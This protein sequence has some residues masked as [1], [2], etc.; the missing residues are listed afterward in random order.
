MT[1]EKEAEIETRLAA[2]SAQMEAI[3]ALLEGRC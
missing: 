3:P 1:R 2:I